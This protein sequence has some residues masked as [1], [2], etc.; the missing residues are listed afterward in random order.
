MELQMKSSGHVHSTDPYEAASGLLDVSIRTIEQVDVLLWLHTS[1]RACSATEIAEATEFHGELV[2]TAL[3][4]L[5]GHGLILVRADGYLYAP[6]NPTVDR[7]V[8]ALARINQEDRA[9]LVALLASFAM[10]R[11]RSAASELL[12]EVLGRER[13][14]R[15]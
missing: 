4:H 8:D 13:R 11:A 15:H 1:N 3:M 6:S 5:I 14:V 9:G 10:Q 7:A 2:S 12:L